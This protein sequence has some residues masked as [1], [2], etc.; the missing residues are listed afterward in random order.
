MTAGEDYALYAWLTFI[1]LLL[2]LTLWVVLRN[3]SELRQILKELKDA[4]R[5]SRSHVE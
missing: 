1:C 5:D 2:M 4:N 3:S